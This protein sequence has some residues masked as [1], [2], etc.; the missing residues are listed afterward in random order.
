MNTIHR[1]ERAGA[2]KEKSDQFSR[3]Q[4]PHCSEIL[5]FIKL[6]VTVRKRAAR[7]LLSFSFS[8]DELLQLNVAD[9]GSRL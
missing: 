1:A 3:Y 9:V 8:E 4:T 7:S 2:L 6:K 5:P